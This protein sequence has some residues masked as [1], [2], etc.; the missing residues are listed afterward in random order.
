MVKVID[1][2]K[3][4]QNYQDFVKS[5]NL[6]NLVFADYTKIAEDWHVINPEKIRPITITGFWHFAIERGDFPESYFN[7]TPPV[8][9]ARPSN[10]I[11][12]SGTNAEVR[13]LDK[14][15][16]GF[17]AYKKVSEMLASRTGD[18]II[19]NPSATTFSIIPS[20]LSPIGLVNPVYAFANRLR[21]FW[22]KFFGKEMFLDDSDISVPIAIISTGKM[23]NYNACGGETMDVKERLESIAGNWNIPIKFIDSWAP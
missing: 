5:M 7:S 17:E 12:F 19:A 3:Q 4:R 2:E 23:R 21:T 10:R 18:L 16:E 11:L 14:I 9:E 8:A 13:D 6:K 1:S 20:G 15:I 22:E